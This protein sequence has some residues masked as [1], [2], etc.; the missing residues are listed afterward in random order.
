MSFKRV[1]RQ[2]EVNQP[3]SIKYRA[4]AGWTDIW[5]LSRY[6]AVWGGAEWMGKNASALERIDG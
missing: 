6:K 4:V 3:S 2:L 1:F 5:A